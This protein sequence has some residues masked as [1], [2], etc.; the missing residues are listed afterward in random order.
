MDLRLAGRFYVCSLRAFVLLF[1][2]YPFLSLYAA[3]NFLLGG[4]D[5]MVE[6]EERRARF[7][8]LM[9]QHW[10]QPTPV[11]ETALQLSISRVLSKGQSIRANEKKSIWWLGDLLLSLL[12]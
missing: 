6:R 12:T 4:S 11:G 9:P 8:R 7:T 5:E 10:N 2:F 3:T 1:Y